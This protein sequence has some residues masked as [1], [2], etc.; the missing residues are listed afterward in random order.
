M[1]YFHLERLWHH[2]SS[3]SAMFLHVDGVRLV[4][5]TG[6]R[7]R[8]VRD[9]LDVLASRSKGGVKGYS[10]CATNL[11]SRYIY[12]CMCIVWHCREPHDCIRHVL[13]LRNFLIR[14]TD[15]VTSESCGIFGCK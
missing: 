3:V 11:L 4:I 1:Q 7:I 9:F 14:T 6:W 12:I 13:K 15:V 5:Q 10:L 8:M 2:H